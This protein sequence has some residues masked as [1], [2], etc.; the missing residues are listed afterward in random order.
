LIGA[1]GRLKSRHT[2]VFTLLP[3]EISEG[4]GGTL[5]ATL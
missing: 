4:R 5:S 2:A 1:E 3:L